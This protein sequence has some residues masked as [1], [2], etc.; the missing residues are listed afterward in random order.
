MLFVYMSGM[1]GEN[2]CDAGTTIL[3]DQ[4]E[5]ILGGPNQILVES[6]H[7]LHQSPCL[8]RECEIT[9]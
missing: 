6:A 5:L 7:F 4:S 8:S 1:Q 2:F 3:V 9:P